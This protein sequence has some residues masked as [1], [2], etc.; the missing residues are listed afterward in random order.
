VTRLAGPGHFWMTLCLLVAAL[1]AACSDRSALRFPHALHLAGIAC[2]GAGKPACLTCVSCHS[3]SRAGAAPTLPPISRCATCHQGDQSPLR[4]QI[5][6]PIEHPYGTIAFDH[7]RH[8][9]L[10]G[11]EGQ[12]VSCHAGVVETGGPRL[13]PMNKCLGCHEHQEQ[14]QRGQCAP[15]HAGAELRRL[16]PQTFLRH[17]GDF[18]VHHGTD[19]VEQ[20]Q[21]CQACHAQADCDGCHDTTQELSVERRRPEAVQA[22]FAHRGDFMTTHPLEAQSQPARCLRCHTTDTCDSCHL[23]RGVSAGLIEGRN[24]HPPGWVGN[25]AGARSFHGAAARRDILLCASCHDQGP[26]TNCI[27]CHKVGGYGGNPHPGGWKS[28]RSESSQ[29]CRYCHG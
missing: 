27:R 26:A 13:P 1:A 3:P 11:V 20:K 23:A 7:D 25:N 22:N 19:A 14:W 10:S 21:L 28:T 12:C 29:M 17:A 2:G 4:A 5:S 8:L 15:C 24:P 18:M 6:A 9:A 16:L